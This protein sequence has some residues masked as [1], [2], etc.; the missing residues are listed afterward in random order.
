MKL[1]DLKKPSK[2]ELD[3]FKKN[4][5]FRKK[6]KHC[7]SFFWT[8][9][10][11]KDNCA[12]P[13]CVNYEFL[14]K[15]YTNRAYDWNEMRSAFLNFFK[16]N[17][18]TIVERYP[19]V[20]RWR[21]DLFF[22]NCSIADFQPWV[23]SGEVDPPANPLTISQPCLRFN[24]LD[25]IGVTGR[26]FS[27]FEMMAH[28]AFNKEGAFI[29]FNE[30]TV[31]LAHNFFTTELR[32]EPEVLV[33]KDAWWE[34]GGNA[35]ACFEVLVDGLEIATLVFMEY[36]GPYDGEYYKSKVTAVDTGYGLNRLVWLSQGTPTAYDCMFAPIIKKLLNL[37]SEEDLPKEVFID[38]IAQAGALD[39]EKNPNALKL[40][41]KIL[42]TLA[43]KYGL[44]LDQVL[45]KIAI[46]ESIYVLCDHT[47]ALAFILSNSVVPSNVKE[48][49]M[50]RLLIRR[51]IRHKKNLGLTLPL[52]EIM[53]WQIDMLKQPFPEIFENRE[54]IYK[55]VDLEESRYKNTLEKGKRVIKRFVGRSQAKEVKVPRKILEEWYES[56]GILPSDVTEVFPNIE[57]PPDF[58]AKLSKKHEP[59]QKLSKKDEL[60][61]MLSKLNLPPTEL[62]FYEHPFETSTH[63]KILKILENYIIL[64]KTLF[65]PE[66]GGQPADRGF[67][68]GKEVLDVKKIGN[69]VVHKLQDTDGLFENNDVFCEIDWL[70]REKHSQHHTATHIVMSAARLILGNHVWQTGAQKGETRARLDITHHSRLKFTDL[71]EIEKLANQI[72]RY[73]INITTKWIDRPTAEKK[74]GFRL[75]QGGVVPGAKIR[76]VEIPGYDVEACAGTH[77]SNTSQ[78][79][80]IKIIKSERIQ[81]G[82]VRLEFSAGDSTIDYIAKLESYLAEV[83]NLWGVEYKQVP[84][85]ARRFFTEWKHQRKEIK[86]LKDL[87]ADTEVINLLNNVKKINGFNFLIKKFENRPISEILALTRKIIN[88][89][90]NVISI[91][92]TKL[93]EKTHVCIAS[94]CERLPAKNL[95]KHL[96]KTSIQVSGNNI[97]AHAFFEP[98]I[99]L[100]NILKKLTKQ[101]EQIN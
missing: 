6:C 45:K 81:D 72:V 99:D 88:R 65:Y 9:H 54:T 52:H 90:S 62:Y 57:I 56:H 5:F 40:K 35:G 34:G 50:A 51:A 100:E 32:I 77:C 23:L 70:R 60:E 79:G 96:S 61:N 75:Y 89:Q 84:E 95:I 80:Y 49:F 17:G 7:N 85:T 59:L 58:M 39:V 101:I 93:G 92:S 25:N 68:H 31:E 67:I 69:I 48:G 4:N 33:Y 37:I 86:K 3:F 78:V 38:Y 19:I 21:N 44:P 87:L 82:V 91:I 63:A 1:K 10:P 15:K 26:H 76:V 30:K 24:D 8:L 97:V 41:N 11:V 20:A 18:H 43:Y 14:G 47:K 55:L 83:A 94:R 13:P 22:T 46:L 74:Y 36:D 53:N 27:M 64:D 71:Q 98:P 42:S 73:S 2:Y 12:D 28:H 29:Y 16:R 66:G